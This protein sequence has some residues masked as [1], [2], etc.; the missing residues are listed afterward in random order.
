MNQ[1]EYVP[2][3]GGASV[4]M[5][6]PT[7]F[8]GIAENLRSREWEYD[9]GF[10]DLVS[11]TRPAR[12]VDVTFY[13]DYE[14]ADILR[15]VADADVTARTPGTFVAQGEWRQR[16]YVLASQPNNLHY[17]T[18]STELKIALLDGAWWRLVERSFMPESTEPTYGTATDRIVSTVGATGSA[19]H[20]LTVFGESVQD[21]GTPTPDNPIGIETVAPTGGVFELW[22]TSGNIA[23]FTP[24]GLTVTRCSASGTADALVLT[25]TSASNYAY[26]YLDI[27][28]PP[29]GS[30]TFSK[31]DTTNAIRML[32]YD[33][34][35][36]TV[37]DTA[38]QAAS[39]VTLQV[40]PNV[41][42][43]RAYVYLGSTSGGTVGD[44]ATISDLQIERGTQATVYKP[45]S[46]LTRTAID[47]QGNVL[48]SLPDGTKDVLSID[49]TGHVVLTKR[50]GAFDFDG[51][52]S[53]SSFTSSATMGGNC[54][55]IAVP[56][57]EFSDFEDITYTST[58]GMCDIAV[59]GSIGSSVS[60]YPGIY[61]KNVGDACYLTL[62]AS[63]T[64]AAEASAYLADHPGKLYMR[65]ATP[66]TIDLGYISMP[67][68]S[69]GLQVYVVAEVMPTITAS[70]LVSS[71]AYLDYPFDY[72]YDY[73]KTSY[74]GSVEPSVL[75]PSDV[76]IVVYGPAVNPYVIVGGNRYEVDITVP[77]GGYLTV[78]GRDKTIKLT[79]ADGTV[80]NAFSYGV[81]GGGAGG[82][83]Y[84]FERIPSGMNEVTFDGSFGF[85]LGWYE[86]E[87]EPP[88]SQ[89]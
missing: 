83:S 33:S 11:A 19:L 2:G 25:R 5:D 3:M 54:T 40:S 69:D 53:I 31:S 59:Y 26:V 29:A 70:W 61:R 36:T 8:V 88:W 86:E 24:S 14:T 13:A 6:G 17:G 7:S 78:D 62:P 75:T 41:A 23:D 67:N 38:R 18:L 45:Y 52:T 72:E 47:L 43:L 81:R 55:R 15:R 27:A 48:A 12:E 28:D 68:V 84:I 35:N 71:D 39:S 64:S 1:L 49:D 77:A 16:G 80:Q 63:L 46:A 20:S 32:T 21:G 58:Y 60:P 37:D 4:Q 22:V 76:H 42:K 30:Y 44:T 66:Q 34:N 87:G 57:S 73:Q 50:V 74:A 82:G 85:D 65:L 9:L 51:D 10:R 56:V 79:L 89:F